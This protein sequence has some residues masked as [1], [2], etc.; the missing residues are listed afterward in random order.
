VAQDSSLNVRG[1]REG[2][3][4][5]F[6]WWGTFLWASHRSIG[7]VQLLLELPKARVGLFFSSGIADKQ[8][9]RVAYELAGDCDIDGS[10]LL[11]SSNHPHLHPNNMSVLSVVI[12]LRA[13]ALNTSVAV[14]QLLLQLPQAHMSLFPGASAANEQP[15]W[16]AH[17]LAGNGGVD[18]RLMLVPFHQTH[19]H[20]RCIFK[21]PLP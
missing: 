3:R 6:V 16:N 11:V 1:E 4:L 15:V 13:S 8:R 2:K 18:D 9:V 14:A 10:L 20:S 7:L 21:P 17:E 19:L 5:T 12:L